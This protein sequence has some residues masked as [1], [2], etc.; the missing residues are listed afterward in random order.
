MT[1]NSNVVLFRQPTFTSVEISS[2]DMA[3]RDDQLVSFPE[4]FGLKLAEKYVAAT[5]IAMAKQ[6][7]NG[8]GHFINAAEFGMK[9]AGEI[10]FVL[11]CDEEFYAQYKVTAPLKLRSARFVF[12]AETPCSEISDFIVSMT[13]EIK[14]LSS[15]GAKGF[16]VNGAVYGL[17]SSNTK[18]FILVCDD[19]FYN[20]Y[21]AHQ[22]E[23]EQP[24]PMAF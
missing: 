13:K 24:L 18:T 1:L 2:N 12:G 3:I 11:F 15:K 22:E 20:G 6:I 10:A 8:R 5:N 21:L 19:N 9:K 4:G 23:V 14:S 17:S 7:K 16:L